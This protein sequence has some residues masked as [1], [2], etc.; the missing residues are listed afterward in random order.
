MD[1][2]TTPVTPDPTQNDAGAGDAVPTAPQ[3]PVDPESP[4]PEAPAPEEGAEALPG[5]EEQ[6]NVQNPEA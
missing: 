6:V 5:G 2:N 3:E 4:A 1:D